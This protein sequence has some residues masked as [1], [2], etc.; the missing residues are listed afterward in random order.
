MACQYAL[1]ILSGQAQAGV[2]IRLDNFFDAIPGNNRPNN[3]N[4]GSNSDTGDGSDSDSDND[5]ESDV[6]DATCNISSFP[7][8]TQVLM[9]D[10]TYARIDRI[11]PGDHVLSHNLDTSVWEPNLVLDQWSH[12]DRG[13]AATVTLSDSSTI[14]A[15]D[16]HH[17]WVSNSNQWVELQHV[18]HGDLLLS[19]SGDITVA[20]VAVGLPQEWTVWELTVEHNHNFTV[21]SG[22]ASILV[23]NGCND[24]ELSDKFRSDLSDAE[25]QQ[26][27]AWTE[28]RTQNLDELDGLL[29]DLPEGL[30]QVTTARNSI[31][32]GMTPDD[33]SGVLQESRGVEIPKADG[34]PFDHINEGIEKLN[35][36]ENAIADLDRVV[37]TAGNTLTGAQRKAIADA[38]AILSE[39]V[40]A[41]NTATVLP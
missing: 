18:E 1:E 29:D 2:L 16:D 32:D 4:D 15:T 41:Y 5:G 35:S 30:E 8:H 28:I 33:V 14:T 7:G 6:N 38:R 13:P 9:A 39:T 26:I 10:S 23:H 40:D 12:L 27:E 34:T 20:D 22:T 3:D 11:R 36:V 31:R 37:A 25:I 21:H 24:D 17:F 19:T